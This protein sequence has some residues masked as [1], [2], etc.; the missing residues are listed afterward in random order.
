MPKGNSSDPFSARG[1]DWSGQGNDPTGFKPDGNGGSPKDGWGPD[2]FGPDWLDSKQNRR[3]DR[4]SKY[5]TEKTVV[6][7]PAWAS[8][9]RV[10][11]HS[12]TA[13]DVESPDHWYTAGNGRKA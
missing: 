11:K 7:T 1:L 3:G 10:K 9:A 4:E 2:S 8:P 5:S 6:D 12:A 13:V